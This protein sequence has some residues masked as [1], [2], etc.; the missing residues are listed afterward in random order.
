ML[1]DPLNVLVVDDDETDF[2][3]IHEA[4]AQVCGQEFRLHHASTYD[5][6]RS[7]LLAD[8]HDAYLVDYFLG[9]G[10]GLD[11]IRE[12]RSARIDSPLIV[13]TG[14]NNTELD[15][16]VM[17]NGASDFL[18]KE[19]ITPRLL[20]RTIRHALERAKAERRL[21][22]LI[23]QDPLTSL[24]NRSMFEDHLERSLARAQRNED[25]LAV[26]FL[27]LNR[28]KEIND[29]LGHHVGDLL[30]IMVADRLQAMTREEDVVARIGG[31][32]FTLLLDSIGSPEDA[33]LV[34]QKIIEGLSEPTPIDEMSLVVT[35]SVGIALYPT[36]GETPIQ[37]MQNADIALYEAKKQGGG[38]YQFFTDDLQVRLKH[39]AEIEKGLRRAL[40]DGELELR[41]QPQWRL[42]DR[43]I[44]GAEALVRWRQPD[45]SLVSPGDFIPVAER[46]GLIIPLGQWVFEAA[47]RQLQEWTQQ[48]WD[49]LSI[50]INVS[51]KQLRAADF[52][53]KTREVIRE[54]G[55]DPARIEV[56]LTEELFADTDPENKETLQQLK[57]MGVLI[58]IDDFGTGYSSMRYLKHF[59][60]HTLKI[61]RSFVSGG[62]DRE[63]AEPVLAQ[64]IIAL[65]KAMGLEVVAEGIETEEQLQFLVT[66]DCER[67]QGFYLSKPVTADEFESLL[68]QPSNATSPGAGK[69]PPDAKG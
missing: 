63:I 53:P 31:D 36:G 51:P 8:Q 41:Y 26:L 16:Q 18:P 60:L 57:A 32:E 27:D 68:A 11:L 39:N 29:L 15:D 20:E 38:E 43:S 12:A 48:G 67:A 56:E 42:S 34:A 59:P 22:S 3:L 30:L 62:D 64:S 69:G 23:K 47:C 2:V 61:D 49:D 28:F 14:A 50:S 58:A 7:A 66:R 37:L 33:A 9:P 45:G 52:I 19:E 10:N 17:E 35:A 54:T 65:A 5:E 25:Q 55:I 4:L 13:L 6:A 21:Q 44:T 40:K 1:S 24:G 46:T